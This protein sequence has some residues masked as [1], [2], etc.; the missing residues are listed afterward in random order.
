[1]VNFIQLSAVVLAG[2][3]VAIADALIKKTSIEGGFMSALKSPLMILILILYIA[4]VG[5]FIYVFTNNWHLGIVH[6]NR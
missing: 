4:Q 6:H 2:L 1:M 3:A 5:L